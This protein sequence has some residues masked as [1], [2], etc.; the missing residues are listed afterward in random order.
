VEAIH[1]VFLGKCTE[2]GEDKLTMIYAMGGGGQGIHTSSPK[3]F[4]KQKK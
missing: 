1:Q 2:G 3:T 4:A